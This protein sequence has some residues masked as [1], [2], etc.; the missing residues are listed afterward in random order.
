M[1]LF[2]ASNDAHFSLTKLFTCFQNHV[3]PLTVVEAEM[4]WV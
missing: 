3:F 2:S 4:D 1:S